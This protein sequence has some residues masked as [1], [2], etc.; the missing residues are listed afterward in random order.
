MGRMTDLNHTLPTPAPQGEEEDTDAPT[1]P[2]QP[3]DSETESPAGAAPTDPS[4]TGDGDTVPLEPTAEPGK[5]APYWRWVAVLS[6]LTLLIIAGMSAYGGYRSGMQMRASAGSTQSAQQV[7]TQFALGLEDMEA[8][9]LDLARQRF[10]WVVSQNPGY[11]GVTEKLAEVIMLMNITA[12]STPAPTPTLTPTPDLRS[13]EE[14]YTQAKEMMAGGDWSNA[15]DTLLRLRKKAPDY[16]E[17]EVDGMLYI[18]LRNQGVSKIQRADLESGT[19]DLALAERFGP[20]D[21][22][23]RNWR[24]WAEFYITGASFWEVDWVRVIEYFSE[25]APV[26]PNLADS[27][28]WT[29]TDRLRIAYARYGDQLAA[30]GDWCKAQEQY[31]NSLNLMADSEVES[32]ASHAAEQCM[33]TM[34]PPTEVPVT[35]TP[36]PTGTG[37][38]PTTEVTPAPTF[39]LQPTEAPT[40]APTAAPTTEPTTAPQ[41]QEPSVTPEATAA[42]ETSDS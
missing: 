36:T 35:G 26:V 6:I 1:L 18:A 4:S 23:A 16:H 14:L 32:S 2:Y 5:G 24:D 27:S 3:N 17:V 40:Q 25:L 8:K 31:D 34:Q 20:L 19:Y 15:I 12:T 39:T 21:A 22:E 37:I 33:L 41:G 42:P 38:A 10:E 11:P 13:V 28:G 7:A 29:A 30:A 9:R